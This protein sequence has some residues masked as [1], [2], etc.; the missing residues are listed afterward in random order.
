MGQLAKKRMNNIINSPVS[1]K[2]LNKDSEKQ[3][4]VWMKSLSYPQLLREFKQAAVAFP[5]LFQLLI[6]AQKPLKSK[7][8]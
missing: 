3:V 8:V 4:S 2:S 1:I 7:I 6:E 5:D